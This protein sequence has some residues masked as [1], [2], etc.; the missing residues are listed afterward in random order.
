MA[1]NNRV[2]VLGATG[3]IGGEVARQMRD[4]GWDVRALKRDAVPWRSNT[5]MASPGFVA[6][7]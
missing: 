2:L 7:R 1:N 3:G 4:A 6:M 5:G